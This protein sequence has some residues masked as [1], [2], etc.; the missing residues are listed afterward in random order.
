MPFKDTPGLRRIAAAAIEARDV[1]LVRLVLPDW[2][3]CDPDGVVHCSGGWP[4]SSSSAATSSWWT[5]L[6]SSQVSC[7]PPKRG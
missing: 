5:E 2:T 3:F 7:D 1:V 4:T 6:R